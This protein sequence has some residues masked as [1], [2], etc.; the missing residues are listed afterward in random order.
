MIHKLMA[1]EVNDDEVF[2]FN[3]ITDEPYGSVN[4][5]LFYSRSES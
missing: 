4:D 5:I 2:V 3:S 1:S